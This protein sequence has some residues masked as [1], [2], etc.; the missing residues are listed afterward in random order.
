[1]KNYVLLLTLST[2]ITAC[3]GSSSSGDPTPEKQAPEANK[4]TL[5]NSNTSITFVKQGDEDWSSLSAGNHTITASEDNQKIQLVTVCDDYSYVNIIKL[6]A[7]RS[8]DYSWCNDEDSIARVTIGTANGSG[9]TI[10]QS[11]LTEV[12][13]ESSNYAQLTSSSSLRTIIAVGYN[14]TTD[15]AYF[16]KKEGLNLIDGDSIEI[17][18]SDTELALEAPTIINPVK[19]GFDFNTDYKLNSSSSELPLSIYI[20]DG[21]PY[22]EVPNK[23]RTDGD[24]YRSNWQ[25]GADSSYDLYAKELNL[26]NEL[27]SPPSELS[28]DNV[29]FSQDKTQ[30]VVTL[31]P[32]KSELPLQRVELEFYKYNPSSDNVYINYEIDGSYINDSS[33]SWDLIDFSSLPTGAPDVI[34]P[35]LGDLDY[36]TAYY[37]SAVIGGS[38]VPSKNLRI[39]TPN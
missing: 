2:L 29:S 12:T 11:R 5:N 7:D 20:K 39:T 35:A 19:S 30:G 37:S 15:K 22:I 33:L 26:V 14:S 32:S 3:G 10:I 28:T 38:G 23:F 16:Y 8:L 36:Y 24:Y 4:I 9:T 21:N 25:F 18:F 17:D 31:T 34:H 13:E 27:A 6:T 1:M